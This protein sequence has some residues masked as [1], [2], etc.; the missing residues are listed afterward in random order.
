MLENLEKDLLETSTTVCS[1]T[2]GEVYASI[3]LGSTETRGICYFGKREIELKDIEEDRE[4]SSFAILPYDEDISD[5]QIINPTI[6]DS[7]E[8]KIT[9]MGEKKWTILKGTLATQFGCQEATTSSKAK[10]DQDSTPAN[11]HS[12]IVMSLIKRMIDTKQKFDDKFSFSINLNLALPPEDTTKGRIDKIKKELEGTYE[13]ILPRLDLKFDYILDAAKIKIISECNAA[14]IYYSISEN[15]IDE[16]SV[17]DYN[18]IV[19]AGGGRSC[20]IAIIKNGQLMF[21]L[22]VDNPELGGAKMREYLLEQISSNK[23][24]SILSQEN[25]ERVIQTGFYRDGKEK[26]CATDELNVTKARLAK[27]CVN[28]IQRAISKAGLQL[29]EIQTIVFYGRLFYPVLDKENNVLSP[30]LSNFIE[31]EINK[32]PEKGYNIDFIGIK[33]DFPIPKGL[34]YYDIGTN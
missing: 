1:D 17:D 28:F 25:G 34:A 2:K 33:K 5:L 15:S 29:S 24:I 20:S 6:Y 22:N 12:Y 7:L 4:K 30:S 13:V 21:R 9:D 16:D 31:K 26:V 14:A 27:E 32:D 8:M 19:I 23:S 10:A 3:D 11:I 18:S